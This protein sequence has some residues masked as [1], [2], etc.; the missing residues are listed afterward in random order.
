MIGRSIWSLFVLLQT[1]QTLSYPKLWFRLSSKHNLQLLNQKS[2]RHEQTFD[3]ESGRK[4]E[5]THFDVPGLLAFTARPI[6]SQSFGQTSRHRVDQIFTILL[7]RFKLYMFDSTRTNTI[8]FIVC[9]RC[10]TLDCIESFYFALSGSILPVNKYS[11]F[12]KR[13]L[14]R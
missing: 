7:I 10:K 13:P 3:L 12:S 1:C 11:P 14:C 4:G 8:V 2:R 5:R 9:K 6:H